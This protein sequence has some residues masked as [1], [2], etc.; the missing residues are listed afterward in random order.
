AV[1][2]AGKYPDAGPSRV[3]W[4][5]PS[6]LPVREACTSCHL[7]V[8]DGSRVMLL[9][10]PEQDK[11]PDVMAK[12]PPLEF[13]CTV[14]HL[15]S[16]DDLSFV[17]A[18]GPDRLGRPFRPGRVALRSC[19]ICHAEQSPLR[20]A[21][22][23]FSWPESCA[24]CHA[25]EELSALVDSSSVAALQYPLNVVRVR[26]W[27]LRHWGEKDGLLPQRDEFEG[28]VS[29]LVSGERKTQA[30]TVDVEKVE[31]TGG[32][33]GQELEVVCPKCGRKFR[34]ARGAEFACPWDGTL[35]V[36]ADK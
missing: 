16:G 7:P 26:E 34:A 17:A 20:M 31:E 21:A 4:I 29:L 15:G 10:Q 23:P 30:K 32:S 12:H 22:I 35:L 13:G 3:R 36:K 27:L 1:I 11:Y 18:H 6:R 19:G 8:A 5:I 14:C 33:P 28:V 2:N 25:G 24:R 9:P